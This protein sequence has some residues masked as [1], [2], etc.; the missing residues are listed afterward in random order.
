MIVLSIDVGMKNLAF[1]LVHC[2]EKKIK[3]KKWD[4]INLCDEIN[5]KCIGKNVKKE[6]CGK[7]AKFYKYNKYYCKIHAKKEKYKIPTK[8]LY[9]N[10]LKKYKFKELKEIGTKYDIS[11]NKKNKTT[12]H[13]DILLDLSN[14]YFNV[15]Q[16]IN[17]NQFN[18][19]QFG[20]NIKKKFNDVFKNEKIDLVLVENQIGPLALRMKTLQGMIMQHF[21]E[22]NITNIKE[23]SASNKLKEFISKKTTYS[24]RK[25]ESIVI[26]KQLL[27]QSTSI[28]IWLDHFNKHKKKDDLADAF[29]QCRWYLKEN[30]FID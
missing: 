6:I 28:H 14:N 25:K 18:L 3:I 4:V 20:I 1:C 11:Y 22:N 7:N 30:K 23:V 8:E 16:N 5:H 26:T 27:F 24:E 21:I 10:K 9:L 29:L 2:N 13:N 19:V 15:K 12:C 17:A